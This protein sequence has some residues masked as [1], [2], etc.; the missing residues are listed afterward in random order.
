M[1]LTPEDGDD[2]M[3]G[4]PPEPDYLVTPAL[5][6]RLDLL[7]HLVE[8]GRQVILV[9]GAPGSGRSRLLAAAAAE[10]GPLWEV[11]AGDGRTR[12]DAASLA[13]LIAQ[14]VGIG[15]GSASPEQLRDGLVRLEQTGRLGV[16]MLDDAD[17][18]GADA[19]QLLFH[20]AHSGDERGDLRVVLSADP[21][22]GFGDQLQAIAPQATLV[23]VVDVPPL[24]DDTL[25]QIARQVLSGEPGASGSV[26]DEFELDEIIGDCAGN[27]G[28]LLTELRREPTPQR[29]LLPAA[30]ASRVGTLR[31][32][33]IAFGPLLADQMAR[34]R[35]QMAA[36]KMATIGAAA[37]LVFLLL[38]GGAMLVTRHAAS[39]KPGTV[40]VALAPP[41]A[42]PAP[43]T[44]QTPPAAPEAAPVPTPQPAAPSAAAAGAAAE[45]PRAPVAETSE[46]N[47]PS[48]EPAS[49]PRSTSSDAPKPAVSPKRARKDAEVEPGPTA[50]TS[51][52]AKDAPAPADN[53]PAEHKAAES[54]PDETKAASSKAYSSAWLKKQ[55][56]QHFVVQLFGGREREAAQQFIRKFDLGDKAAVV[57]TTRDGRPWFVVVSGL[58]TTRTAAN[59]AVRALP[60][61]LAKQKP[62]PRTVN[63]LRN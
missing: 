33:A 57:E 58:Y 13:D 1:E 56:G 4:P 48:S 59:A 41:V 5:R 31:S 21:A 54:R 51:S 55:K 16:L 2:S 49:A 34:L 11:I 22:S 40:N 8:F 36:H 32:R 15:D 18:L 29:T 3:S 35:T 42:A 53:R 12:T 24:D 25:R 52:P 20:L 14:A 28:A 63:S 27:P 44:A 45:P 19:C 7:L 43:T 38:A 39:V 37:G 50:T 17:G 6:Q 30:L 9:Q 26:E 61:A 23:H 47:S 46:T 10:A 60:P 62:W